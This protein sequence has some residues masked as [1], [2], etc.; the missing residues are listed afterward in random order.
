[1]ESRAPTC[2]RRWMRRPVTPRRTAPPSARSPSRRERL[3]PFAYTQAGLQLSWEL[4]LWGRLRRLN[5][6]A[7]A[8]YLASEEA[9]NGV[10]ISLISDV[11]TT[12]F[13]L[14]ELDLELEIGQQNNGIAR[15]N[16]R[17][18]QLRKDRGAANGLEVHQAE[19]FLYTTTAQIASV[20]RSIAQTE[21]A[22]NLLLAN[23]PA[24]VPRGQA[25][26]QI[27]LGAPE[28]PAG[29]P[30]SLLERRPDIRQAEDNLIAANAQIGAARALFFPQIS[31]TG[32]LGGQSQPLTQLFTGP[33]R[34]ASIAP[35]RCCLSS[36]RAFA[37]ACGLPRR[38]SARCCSTYQKSIYGALR[39]VADA[40]AAHT[41]TREQRGEEE[42]LVTALSES[43]RL[44]T[45]R[46][47]GGLDSYLA[48]IGCG[49]EPVRRPA[50]LWRNCGCWNCSRW[51]S[52][53]A[54]WAAAGN[55]AFGILS[56]R[57]NDSHARVRLRCRTNAP[58][59]Q[60]ASAAVPVSAL[61]HR[62]PGSH[63][64]QLRRPGYDARAWILR[65]RL[66]LGSGIFFAGYVLLEIPGTLLVELWSARKWIARIMISWGVVGSLTGLIHTAHQFY[67]ARFIL[68][69]AEAGFFP[70]VVVYLAHW[71]REQDR[72]RA[73]AM[74]M[75]AIPI[76][77]VIGAPISGALLQIHWLGYA[78]WRWLLFLEGVPAVIAGFVALFYLTDRPRDAR[79]AAGRRTRLDH[80]RIGARSANKA[81][82][83]AR[84]YGAILDALQRSQCDSA[85]RGLF[86]G[87]LRAVRFQL[88]AAQDDSEAIGFRLFRGGDDRGAAVPGVLA[89][90]AAVELELGSYGRAPL[91][92][93][94]GLSRPG[95]RFSGRHLEWQE[96]PNRHSDVFARGHRHQRTL[97]G[98]LGLTGLLAGRR[99][100]GSVRRRHQLHRQSGRIRRPVSAGSAE[101]RHWRLSTGIWYLAGASV[102][103]AILILLVTV[104]IRTSSRRGLLTR[105]YTLAILEKMVLT[106][107]IRVVGRMAATATR[108]AAP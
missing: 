19:Q 92:H 21:D 37:P 99:H 40:L 108:T 58:P 39:E 75:S 103:A 50:R 22:L 54:R 51:C 48:S 61:H 105:P 33:A 68:G 62:V 106:V 71:Y 1:M 2:S 7:R 10:I 83:A 43:V 46:Y 55:S 94:S 38:S 16:L 52:C 24:E 34:M 28:L 91:A 11:M 36:T 47:R 107:G 95:R 66:R 60:P 57:S 86:P 49:A 63:Q 59:H 70:G 88:L 26:E 41:R 72:A 12:Y 84:P 79:L 74:F 17:L 3:S 29:L 9:R 32:F 18:I 102:L 35:S 81:K 77:Q 14:R 87:S 67:W 76:A 25:L 20:E 64:H 53:I 15:D 104:E 90:D 101:H 69:V 44:S 6:A 73:M 45:L 8:Q 85:H 98:F 65:P 56:V 89:G 96:H 27:T 78:G 31:L 100:S 80:G 13:S 97:A 5:E 82:L 23:A 42:K 93:R 30:S 4:D